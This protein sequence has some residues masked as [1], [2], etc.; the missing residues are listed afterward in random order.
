MVCNET[1]NIMVCS[2]HVVTPAL[3]AAIVAA[4]HTKCALK[5]AVS[6]PAFA[7][8]L[9]YAIGQSW[10]IDAWY[11]IYPYIRRLKAT[12]GFKSI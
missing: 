1:H 12:F 3:E 5:M 11:S 6:I 7:N 2:N 10:S 4:P 9:L 8:M